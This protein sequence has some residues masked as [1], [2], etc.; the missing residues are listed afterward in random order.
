[1]NLD[2]NFLFIPDLQIPF[3]SPKA[4]KFCKYLKQH[5]N[6]P[7]ENV[8][9]AGD[10]TDQYWGGLYKQ[11]IEAEHTAN[12]ELEQSI[13]KLREWYAAFPRMKLC[14]SNHGTRWMRRAFEF[15]IPSLMMRRYEHVIQAPDTWI[16]QKRWV[17]RSKNPWCAEHGDKYGGNFPH[18]AA[19]MANGV[20]TAIGHH[21][22]LFGI[23]HIRTQ[24]V[25]VDHTVGYDV[26]GAVCGALIDF[27]RYAFNYAREAKKK[28]KNGAL[29]V[30]DKG[31]QP[32][33]IPE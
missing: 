9:N 31:R 1:M 33:L 10:E 5:Y 29:I 32:V 12:Q 24:E 22:S 21:H 27:D 8:I 7:D 4:L 17:V 23:Q 19:A 13:E 26:W 20:S 6:V 14:I 30:L 16:W 3:E 11:S 25:L 2:A 18:V 15:G 28:P